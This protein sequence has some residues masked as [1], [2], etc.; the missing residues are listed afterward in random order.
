MWN[1]Y[2]HK[3]DRALLKVSIENIW[4]ELIVFSGFVN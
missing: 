3:D 2:V 4:C 1:G